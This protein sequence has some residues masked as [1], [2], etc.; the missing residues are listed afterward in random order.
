MHAEEFITQFTGPVKVMLK[1]LA[2]L[3]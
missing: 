1:K 2:H 3:I